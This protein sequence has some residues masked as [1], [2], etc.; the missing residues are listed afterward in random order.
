LAVSHC[1]RRSTSRVVY[2]L[3]PV[4]ISKSAMPDIPRERIQNETALLEQQRRGAVSITVGKVL[5]W[6]DLLLAIF[7]Y[8]GIRAGSHLYLWWVVG[9]FILGV[10]LMVWGKSVRSEAS[11]RLAEMSPTVG[12]RDL[13]NEIEQQRRAS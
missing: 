7:V 8:D 4:S 6:M 12:T 10:G 11:R 1:N 3:C 2:S 5:L 13:P 9:E